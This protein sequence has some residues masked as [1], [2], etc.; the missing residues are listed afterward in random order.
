MTLTITLADGT[1]HSFTEAKRP[2]YWK[3]W[4]MQQLPYGTSFQGCT[5]TISR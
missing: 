2:R 5:F 1:S 4:L 3:S